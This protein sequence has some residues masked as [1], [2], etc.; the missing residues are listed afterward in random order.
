VYQV[1]DFSNQFGP[2]DLNQARSA[3]LLGELCQERTYLATESDRSDEVGR[4]LEGYD[5]LE[6]P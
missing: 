3:E 6:G 1:R 2:S 4:P 5:P